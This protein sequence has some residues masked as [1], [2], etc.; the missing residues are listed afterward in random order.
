MAGKIF[1][2]LALGIVEFDT[3][4]KGYKVTNE[5]LKKIDITHFEDILAAKS[6]YIAMIID[7]YERIQYALEFAIGK[8]ANHIIDIALIGNMHKDLQRFINKEYHNTCLD[9][10]IDIGIIKTDTFATCIEKAN[11]ILHFANV[12]LIDI[13]YSDSLNGNC[14]ITFH[15]STS[16]IMAS[17]D[18]VGMGELIP[19]PDKKLLE[20]I[21][22]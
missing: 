10:I 16:N 7:K 22:N 8:D 19:K 15:G 17:I 1:N 2:K 20:R 21:L 11:Q 5:M 14:L 3:I 12:S 6:K 18:K 4:P 13:N 9:E